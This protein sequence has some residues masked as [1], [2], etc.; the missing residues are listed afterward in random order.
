[1]GSLSEVCLATRSFTARSLSE[2]RC[3]QRSI[4]SPA[5]AV[6]LEGRSRRIGKADGKNAVRSYE[7]LLDGYSGRMTED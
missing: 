1:M 2:R 7:H 3:R 5:G 6:I 4:E